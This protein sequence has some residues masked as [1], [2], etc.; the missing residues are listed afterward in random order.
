MKIY[1]IILVRSKSTRLENKC[2]LKFGKKNNVIEHIIQRCKYYKI[3]PIICTTKK[4]ED[5]KLCLIAKKNKINFFTGSSKNKILRISDCCKFYKIK[6]FHTI[7]ADDPFFC[8]REVSISMN[9]LLKGYDIIKPSMSSSN[10]GASVGFSAFSNVF[11]DL[12]SKLKKEED[13]EMMWKYFDIE[14]KLKIKVLPKQKYEIKN[15]R[16]TLDY[17]EDYIFLNLIREILGNNAQRKNIFNLL[18]K[19]PQLSKINF[20][21]NNEWQINQRNS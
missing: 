10:G 14:K 20:F 4:K 1:G 3:T 18:K 5:K 6:K 21:R 13:T 12:S 15:C 2:F 8:G 9:F 19:I 16:L 11:H 17:Y 7:D